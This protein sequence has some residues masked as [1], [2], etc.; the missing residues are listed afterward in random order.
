LE[1]S[2]AI[3]QKRASGSKASRRIGK[4]P[5]AIAKY[6]GAKLRTAQTQRATADVIGKLQKQME[7]LGEK[8]RGMGTGSPWVF[9]TTYRLPKTP[10]QISGRYQ[11]GRANIEMNLSP[12]RDPANAEAGFVEGLTAQ[13]VGLSLNVGV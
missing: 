6:Q 11:Q 2:K 12:N 4:T 13:N 9:W 7:Q 3:L 5:G 8:L 10:I 1:R